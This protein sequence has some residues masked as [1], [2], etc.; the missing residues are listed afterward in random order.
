MRWT[1]AL[2]L[3][4]AAC[5]PTPGATGTATV[6]VDEPPATGCV[7]VFQK[8]IAGEMETAEPFA[9]SLSGAGESLDA[10]IVN[11]ESVDEWAREA[12]RIGIELDVAPEEFLAERCAQNEE[13]AVAPICQ[14]LG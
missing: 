9:A 14:E 13:L 4:I 5:S 2:V 8:A 1:V 6:A 3:M 11:C 7:E 12:E 10:T